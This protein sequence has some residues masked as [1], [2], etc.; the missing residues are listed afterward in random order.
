MAAQ[1]FR[2]FLQHRFQSIHASLAEEWVQGFSSLVMKLIVHSSAGRMVVTK[3][4][5]FLGILISLA[6]RVDVVKEIKIVNM[7]FTRRY[8]DDWAWRTL[9]PIAC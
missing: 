8:A 2:F 3:R 7:N 6:R 4:F 9:R 5:N 1:L